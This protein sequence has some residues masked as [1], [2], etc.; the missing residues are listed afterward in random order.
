MF[1]LGTSGS[2]GNM[3]VRARKHLEDIKRLEKQIFE[4]KLVV[5]DLRKQFLN[6]K[7]CTCPTDKEK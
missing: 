7:L 2:G 5:A 4:L 6:A 3:F 1:F